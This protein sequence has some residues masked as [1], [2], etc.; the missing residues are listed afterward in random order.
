MKKLALILAFVSGS[1]ISFSQNNNSIIPPN[2]IEQSKFSFGFKGAF[3]HSFLMPY[4]DCSFKPSWDA[5][6]SAIYSPFVHWGF[7]LD[8]TYSAEGVKFDKGTNTEN[9]KEIDLNYVR[10]PAKVIYFFRTYE[11][12]FRPKVAFGPTIG[13]LTNTSENPG[14]NKVDFGANASLGFNYRLVRAVWLNVDASYYQGL[15]DSYNANN[16]NDLNGNV[17]L[18]MGLSFGF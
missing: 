11:K 1:I 14:F 18:N 12:D 6:V 13:F 8:A 9:V 2:P 15:I 16:E 5:G 7:G 4:S 3:G 10:V 17:R